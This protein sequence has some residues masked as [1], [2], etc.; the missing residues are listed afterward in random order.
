MRPISFKDYEPQEAKR[1]VFMSLKRLN[2]VFPVKRKKASCTWLVHIIWM[3][4]KYV[5]KKNRYMHI[6]S[7][8]YEWDAK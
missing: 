8:T 7:I 5:D 2:E 6:S 3:R 4:S 1:R